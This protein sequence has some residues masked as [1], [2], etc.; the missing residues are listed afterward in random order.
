MGLRKRGLGGVW[1]ASRVKTKDSASERAEICAPG[2]VWGLMR[3]E[4]ASRR[5]Q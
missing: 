3:P 4:W 2:S 5:G 1:V